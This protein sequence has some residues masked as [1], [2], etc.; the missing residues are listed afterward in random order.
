MSG[1]GSSSCVEDSRICRS[2][3]ACNGKRE[4]RQHAGCRSAPSC[5]PHLH[6]TAQCC[7]FVGARQTTHF[8]QRKCGAWRIVASER[9]RSSLPAMTR[10][11]LRLSLWSGLGKAALAR[12]GPCGRQLTSPLCG[13]QLCASRCPPTFPVNVSSTSCGNTAGTRTQ[14]MIAQAAWEATLPFVRTLLLILPRNFG[15]LQRR[16]GLSRKQSPAVGTSRTAR[17]RPSVAR[18]CPSGSDVLDGK[19]GCYM[20]PAGLQLEVTEDDDQVNIQF[21]ESRCKRAACLLQKTNKLSFVARCS[22]Y[23]SPPSA[24]SASTSVPTFVG[25]WARQINSQN[26]RTRPALAFSGPFPASPFVV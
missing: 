8:L 4:T 18:A 20:C 17:D 11:A 10:Y 1:A 15:C 3:P 14:V 25:T 24:A 7:W 23:A 16:T 19:L 9:K 13:M 6:Q 22:Q 12:Q 2:W 26:G 21:V 5:C